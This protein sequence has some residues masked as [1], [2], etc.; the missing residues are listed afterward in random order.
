MFTASPD[1]E[2][3]GGLLGCGMHE[4]IDLHE[5]SVTLLAQFA[6]RCIVAHHQ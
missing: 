4:R 1:D 6:L 2:K 3:N 5:E